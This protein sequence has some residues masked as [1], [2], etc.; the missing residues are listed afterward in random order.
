MSNNKRDKL[1]ATIQDLEILAEEYYYG[2]KG[3]QASVYLLNE[4]VPENKQDYVDA[5]M[6]MDKRIRVIDVAVPISVYQPIQKLG[7]DTQGYVT[8]YFK[9]IEGQ[10]T[11]PPEVMDIFSRWAILNNNL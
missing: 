6:D 4:G 2:H 10:G 3:I 5:V 9:E 1:E 8:V 11:P 7:I